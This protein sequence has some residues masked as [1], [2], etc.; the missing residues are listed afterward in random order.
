MKKY[1]LIIPM[2]MLL[3]FGTQTLKAQNEQLVWTEFTGPF[4]TYVQTEI[5]VTDWESAYLY[6]QPTLGDVSYYTLGS[7]ISSVNFYNGT[8]YISDIDLIDLYPDSFGGTA[9]FEIPDNIDKVQ[10]RIHTDNG[11]VDFY[12]N[13]GFV[14][15]LNRGFGSAYEEAYSSGYSQALQ[16]IQVNLDQAYQEG[17]TQGQ[18][19][20]ETDVSAIATFIPQTMSVM[21]GFFFQIFGV[22]IMGISMLNV[23]AVFVTISVTFALFKVLIK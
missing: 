23:L 19:D 20:T 17:Y 5:D 21:A 9:Y 12:N 15:L 11:A 14:T 7:G 3:L 18:L 4:P 8:T 10:I 1:F 6:L 2:I 16:D 22:E 13:V